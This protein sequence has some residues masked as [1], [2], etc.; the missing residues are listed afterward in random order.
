VSVFNHSL[1]Y[2]TQAPVAALAGI[3]YLVVTCGPLILSTKP[4]FRW[5]GAA[6]LFFA[7]VA[8]ALFFTTFT[9]VWCFFCRA[10]KRLYLFL[11]KGPE[12]TPLLKKG[13][14]WYT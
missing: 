14:F 6:V 13:G 10:L 4:F 12:K 11:F 7:L 3:I 9:S 8:A 5:L 1:F 2:D